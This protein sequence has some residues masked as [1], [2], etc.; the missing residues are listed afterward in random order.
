[1]IKDNTHS[2]TDPAVIWK[3]IK[4]DLLLLHQTTEQLQS[5]GCDV[6]QLIT[7]QSTMICLIM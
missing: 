3:K 4:K 6:P 7:L 5:S 1:M 2:A